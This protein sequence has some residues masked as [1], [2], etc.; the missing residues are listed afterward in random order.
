MIGCSCAHLDQLTALQL[1]LMSATAAASLPYEDPIVTV[2]ALGMSSSVVT[3]GSGATTAATSGG[4]TVTA[5]P[6]ANSAASTA[7]FDSAAS[8]AAASPSVQTIVTNYPSSFTTCRSSTLPPGTTLASS[9]FSIDFSMDGSSAQVGILHASAIIGEE[10]ADAVQ[11]GDS[12]CTDYVVLEAGWWD[13]VTQSWRTDGC[14]M[15]GVSYGPSTVTPTGEVIRG[16]PSAQFTCNHTTEFAILQSLRPSNNACATAVFSAW[17]YAIFMVIYGL[18]GS[19]AL[20]QTVRIYAKTKLT[21]WLVLS[22]HGLI[23]GVGLTRALSMA[24]FWA[25]RK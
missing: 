9:L 15:D 3:S 23:V 1:A 21:H 2:N 4:V 7:N 16:A 5:Q 12:G 18:I 22:Q 8:L 14:T 17:W 20:V 25:M 24:M 6:Q 19:Y 10:T 13:P 11:L